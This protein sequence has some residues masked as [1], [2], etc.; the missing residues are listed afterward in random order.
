MHLVDEPGRSCPLNNN[1]LNLVLDVTTAPKQCQLTTL[2]DQ[3][4]CRSI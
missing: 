3:A 4:Q 1:K 2:K